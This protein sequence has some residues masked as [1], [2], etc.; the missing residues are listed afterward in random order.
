[1]KLELVIIMGLLSEALTSCGST[2]F[3]ENTEKAKVSETSEVSEDIPSDQSP[4]D[5]ETQSPKDSENELIEEKNTAIFPVVI[6]GSYLNCDVSALDEGEMISTEFSVIRCRVENNGE[7]VSLNPDTAT[8]TLSGV[9]DQ[10]EAQS[11]PSED[12]D[13]LYIVPTSKL[14]QIKIGIT[15]SGHQDTFSN[16]LDISEMM[17]ETE[18]DSK[19]QMETS[20]P[21]DVSVM[22]D[23]PFTI[24]DETKLAKIHKRINYHIGN[25][26]WSRNAQKRCHHHLQKYETLGESQSIYLTVSSDSLIRSIT[27]K[28]ICGS[29]DAQNVSDSIQII[30]MKTNEVIA[31][32][33]LPNGR[34]SFDETLYEGDYQI[35]I[36]S[37]KGDDIF[38]RAIELVKYGTVDVDAAEVKPL[39]RS[40][41]K[42]RGAE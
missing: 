24:S 4:G 32:S 21:I 37:E 39:H 19:Q 2:E 5:I 41:Y 18:E 27:L 12:W 13:I 3:E 22:N 40:E 15:I 29:Q 23:I 36:R 28:G 30:N 11:S 31:S 25:G 33:T 34:V 17:S 7:K 10:F 38:I 26:S 8:W 1:M 14:S 16:E 6:S 35:V 9:D 20:T 42:E